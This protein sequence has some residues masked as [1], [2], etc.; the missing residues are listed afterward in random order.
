MSAQLRAV[1]ERS[2]AANR[3]RDCLLEAAK[4]REIKDLQVSISA[5]INL[6]ACLLQLI[7]RKSAPLAPVA[8]P[9]PLICQSSNVSSPPPP[10]F[11]NK[12]QAWTAPS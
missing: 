6:G 3:M 5:A 10:P 9:S 2:R 4:K 7:K 1:L 11:L 8:Q 12:P